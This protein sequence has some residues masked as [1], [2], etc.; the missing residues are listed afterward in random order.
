M[1]KILICFFF[2]LFLTS[3]SKEK[4]AQD[5]IVEEILTPCDCV[6]SLYLVTSEINT[7]KVRYES[8]S[9]SDSYEYLNENNI[10]ES[11]MNAIDEKCIVYEGADSVLQSCVDYQNLVLEMRLYGL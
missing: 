10:L 11:I 7:L 1:K 3:C 2:I 6:S 8:G 5:I 9:I 4:K